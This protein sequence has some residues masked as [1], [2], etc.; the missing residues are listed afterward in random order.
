MSHVKP[1]MDF[2]YQ[3]IAFF[4]TEV[5][6]RHKK[7]KCVIEWKHESS[8]SNDMKKKFAFEPQD[9]QKPRD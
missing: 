8:I 9:D 4:L 2:L 7:E 5:M 6:W 1:K 3:K